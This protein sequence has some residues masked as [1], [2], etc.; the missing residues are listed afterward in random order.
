M[1]KKLQVVMIVILSLKNV[2]LLTLSW[3]TTLLVT[4][5]HK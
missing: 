2:N 4:T 3:S 5:L 1:S